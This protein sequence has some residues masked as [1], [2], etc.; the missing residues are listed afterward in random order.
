MAIVQC[1]NG[2]YYEDSRD[3]VC[4]YCQKL[5][6]DVPAEEAGGEQITQYKPS[7]EDDDAALTEAYGENVDDNEKTVGVFLKQQRNLLTSGWLVCI[8]G[9]EKGA[10]YTIFA[11]RNFAGRDEMMDIVLRG[12]NGICRQ[13]HCSLVYD[14]YSN[15]FFAVAG[16]GAL[17]INGKPL[18][19]TAELFEND[20]LQLGGSSYLFIPFCKGDRVWK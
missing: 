20:I 17:Y 19:S 9:F 2:H 18:A 16:E 14:P 10:S 5:S 3:E 6:N 8:D 12:D 15:R 11:G 1:A 4:P 7:V 13:R